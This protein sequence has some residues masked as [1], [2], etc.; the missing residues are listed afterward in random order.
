MSL[1]SGSILLDMEK[2]SR[3][4]QDVT[5]SYG[6]VISQ[7]LSAVGTSGV[8]PPELDNIAIGY[9]VIQYQETDWIY[10]TDR[11][12]VPSERLSGT[13]YGRSKAVTGDTGDRREV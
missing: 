10:K 3:S 4:Y 9:P 12:P 1:A 7:A 2:K 11:K 5:M 13:G 8:Y 6:Q